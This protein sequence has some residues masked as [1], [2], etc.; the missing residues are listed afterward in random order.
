MS[1]HGEWD[2]VLAAGSLATLLL[3]RSAAR[4]WLARGRLAARGRPA[5]GPPGRQLLALLVAGCAPPAVLPTPTGLGVGIAVMAGGAWVLRPGRVP[6]RPPTQ[7]ALAVDL[8]AAAVAAGA[9]L[10]TG[11]EAAAVAV[12]PH[13]QPFARAAAALRLGADP[14][15]AVGAEPT[16]RQVARAVS[17][18]QAHGVGVTG[19]L[20]RLAAQLR[21]EATS[22][23][24]ERARR[25]GVQVVAPLAA[26]FLPAFVL[27]AVVPVVLGL[28]Q[29]AG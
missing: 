19:A 2:T 5:G 28:A 21:A 29:G 7:L 3:W 22:A 4:R 24:V 6:E 12:A 11:L 20:E 26:C 25:A 18:A 14:L 23:A 15:V 13:G 16:L 27:V 10:A 17:R 9:P 8:L 1:V